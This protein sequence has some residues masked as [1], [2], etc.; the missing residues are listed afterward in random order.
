MEPVPLLR[1]QT[2]AESLPDIVISAADPLNLAGIL[3]PG[4]RLPAV[5]GNRILLRNGLPLAMRTRR[6]IRFLREFDPDEQISVRE[7]L[8]KL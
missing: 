2:R 6:E 8:G 3:L 1:R 7:R 5:S 4:E